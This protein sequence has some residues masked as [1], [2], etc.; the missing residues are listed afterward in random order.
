LAHFQGNLESSDDKS[1]HMHHYN[2]NF[3][4]NMHMKEY[5]KVHQDLA[6]AYRR[7]WCSVFST[8]CVLLN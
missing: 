8:H 1:Q 2:T 7:V 5:E 6:V 4:E 3:P